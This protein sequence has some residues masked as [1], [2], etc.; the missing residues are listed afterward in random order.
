MLLCAVLCVVAFAASGHL[1]LAANGAARAPKPSP[2]ALRLPQTKPRAEVQV[3]GRVLDAMGYLLAGAE[4]GIGAARSRTDA[5]GRFQL[6]VEN[7]LVA[8][9]RIDAAGHRS[10]WLRIS[11]LAGE[12]VVAVLEPSAPWDAEALPSPSPL[13]PSGALRGEGFVRG[14]DR[15]P[16]D[17]AWV[18]V[19]ETGA[20]A[21]TDVGGRYEIALREGPNT[22]IVQHRGKDDGGLCGRGEP[23]VPERTKGR[24]PMPDLLLAEGGAVRGTVR[25]P[26]GAPQPGAPVRVAGEGFARTLLAGDGG[27]FRLSGLAPG[28]YEVTALAHHG[29][30]GASRTVQL[31]VGQLS[32]G[33]ADC[34]LH[35][36]SAA[37]RRLRVVDESGAAVRSVTVAT[38]IEGQRREVAR[39]DAEGYVQLRASTSDASYEVRAGA[40]LQP[41]RV[42]E[43][44]AE[45]D[46]LVVAMP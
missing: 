37:L 4:V 6:A 25:D 18:V 34:E 9:L 24:V 17:D 41:R 33:T 46:Q 45:S 28:S 30:L 19:A 11:P 3:S 1:P 26:D 44:R 15:A 10:R 29:A 12:T 20:M 32:A 36:R 21:R 16:L 40:E 42:V 43:N 5:D 35:L 39:G 7:E 27:V 23:F 31:G 22:V 38:S 13:V 14:P 8:D 2:V